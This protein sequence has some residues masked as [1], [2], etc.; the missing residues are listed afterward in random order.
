MNWRR[1]NPR[2][3]DLDADT[4]TATVPG[5][6]TKNGQLAVQPL[7]LDVA[8]ALR[9]YLDIRSIRQLLW[10][11]TWTA[12][13]AKMLRLDLAEATAAL[14]EVDPEAEGIA[15]VVQGPNGPEY[16]DFH[17]L[18]HSYISNLVAAGVNPKVAQDLAGI[19][20]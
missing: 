4:P 3:F 9:D 5:A 20:P 14:K 17:S 2:R 16:A 19:R 1:S 10:P 13:A 8:A 15:Y 6:Y 12:K 18:R 11:G 7:P